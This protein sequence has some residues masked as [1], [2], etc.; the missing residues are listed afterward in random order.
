MLDLGRTLLVGL[1]ETITKLEK[2]EHIRFSNKDNYWDTM[3]TLP[4]GLNKMKQLRVLGKVCL[5]NDSQV[6]REIG[7][8]KQLYKLALALHDCKTIYE[9]V[10]KELALSLS[11][12]YSLR[13]L[14]IGDR[15]AGGKVLNFLH[16]VP[17]P[18][19]LLKILCITGDIDRL[20]RW[21]GSLTHLVSFTAFRATLTDDHLFGILCKLPNLKTMG[22]YWRCYND[23]RDELVARSSHKFPVLRD[24]ILGGYVPKAIQFEEE[25]MEKLERIELDFDFR[26]VERSIAGMEYLTNLKK[27]TLNGSKDNPE[28]SHAVLEQLKAENERPSRSNRF[29]I[30]VKYS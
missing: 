20:P 18:P 2:L 23:D 15:S 27:F 19:R 1:P 7:E 21:I 22:V 30:A 12:M 24:L 4:R 6:A 9:D 28:L 14:A 8:L 11:K 26:A 3:W 5:G 13:W 25:S 16:Q 10:L 17:T 29:Q